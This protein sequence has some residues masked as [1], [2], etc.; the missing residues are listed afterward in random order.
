VINNIN[1]LENNIIP[2]FS[3]LQTINKTNGFCT[4]QLSTIKSKN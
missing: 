2:Y 1:N 4:R 3:K